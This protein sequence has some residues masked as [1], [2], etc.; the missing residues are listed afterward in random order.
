MDFT[1]VEYGNA[2]LRR[3]R[4]Y[5][6]MR[7]AL[8]EDGKIGGPVG[9]DAKRVAAMFSGF[10]TSRPGLIEHDLQKLVDEGKLRMSVRYYA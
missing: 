8:A 7:E 4:L 10:Y 1:G 5:R 2:D 3:S 6:T 9:M